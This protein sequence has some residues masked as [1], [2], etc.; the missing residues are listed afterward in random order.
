MPL[1]DSGCA[2]V[3][4]ALAGAYS[5]FVMGLSTALK[6]YEIRPR[7]PSGKMFEADRYAPEGQGLFRA[8]RRAALST[9]IVVGLIGLGISLLCK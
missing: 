2:K 5:L 4:M 1:A 3:A 8:H 7:S 6:K 9:P